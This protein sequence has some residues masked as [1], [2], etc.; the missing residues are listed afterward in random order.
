MS[1]LHNPILANIIYR[2]GIIEMYGTGIRRI[3]AAYENSLIKPKFDVTEN[4][5]EITLPVIQC[6]STLTADQQK[7]YTSLSKSIPLSISEILET[8]NFKT[9]KSPIHS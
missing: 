7:I 1:I 8:T 6:N 4:L 5:I 9:I 3:N 2:L